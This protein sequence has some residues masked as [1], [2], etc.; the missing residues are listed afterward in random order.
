[1][2]CA[3][4]AVLEGD[5]LDVARTQ[6]TTSLLRWME[7][8]HMFAIM[9]YDLLSTVGWDGAERLEAAIDTLESDHIARVIQ[10]WFLGQPRA[11][12]TIIPGEERPSFE[13]LD[14][15]PVSGISPR[16][17]PSGPAPKFS[18]VVP[19]MSA[20]SG[21]SDAGMLSIMCDTLPSGAVICVRREHGLPLSA[22]H[23][24]FR[25]RGE[26]E[27]DGKEGVAEILHRLIER[28]PSWME[29]SAYTQT[30]GTLGA[31]VK[32]T[33]NPYIPFDDYYFSPRWGYIRM[34]TP[35]GT[36]FPAARLVIASLCSPTMDSLAV[37]N[38]R[39]SVS[40]LLFR[41]DSSPRTA[42]S[43]LFWGRLL[44]GDPRRR[45]AL[46]IREAVEHVG[47]DDVKAFSG[48]YLDGSNIILTVSTTLDA[49][50][51][52]DSLTSILGNL[53]G[54]GS[55]G[56][57]LRM[58]ASKPGPWVVE[59]SLGVGQ[60]YIMTGMSLRIAPSEYQSLELLAAV[61]G[62]RMERTLREE[63]GLAYGLGAFTHTDDNYG[64]L[65]AYIGTRPERLLEAQTDLK[66]LFAELIAKPFEDR[67]ELRASAKRLQQRTI[68]R[69]LTREG[70]AMA[71]GLRMLR[72]QEPT[73]EAKELAG[74]LS[75]T[76]EH[77]YRLVSRLDRDE[78]F[79]AVVR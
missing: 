32:A 72:G 42:A 43:H 67:L 5:Y 71:M 56:P 36:F 1:M 50:A 4:R 13:A 16:S 24:L 52:L 64:V 58:S 38:I 11:V 6:W 59:D 7:R 3:A 46:G 69:R 9:A 20:I 30:L 39:Q 53:P 33:D 35:T 37:S 54:A 77:L 74:Y 57:S 26:L 65:G 2:E 62:R 27:P 21:L 73:T 22:M 75:I 47:V 45:S 51:C 79:W 66:R 14:P 10:T 49:K 78:I 40:G 23:V 18:E 60:G 63:K 29:E 61:L 70:R 44:P 55:P 15:K 28:G 48:L 34:T 41:E 31:Q 68:L 17:A 25:R 12:L 76:P 19:E 8:P